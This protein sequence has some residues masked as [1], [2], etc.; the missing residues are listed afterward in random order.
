MSILVLLYKVRPCIHQMTKIY[1]KRGIVQL[2]G[3]DDGYQEG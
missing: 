3:G 1:A 2:Q